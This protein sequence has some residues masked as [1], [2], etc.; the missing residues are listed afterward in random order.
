MYDTYRI[1]KLINVTS[2][3]MDIDDNFT[4]S[5]KLYWNLW[6][7]NYEI[8]IVRTRKSPKSIGSHQQPLGIM[9]FYKGDILV[10]YLYLHHEM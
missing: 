7:Y 9:F 3:T 1:A 4:M 10:E 6:L 8:C 5:I 2:E